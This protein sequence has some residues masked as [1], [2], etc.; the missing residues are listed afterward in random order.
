M[1]SSGKGSEERRWNGL[2][3]GKREKGS[4]LAVL[5]CVG[6]VLSCLVMFCLILSCWAGKRNGDRKPSNGSE[7]MVHS[8]GDNGKGPRH[9]TRGIW[10]GAMLKVGVRGR[11]RVKLRLRVRFFACPLANAREG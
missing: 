9:R 11:V 3:L 4:V 10:V 5:R 8:R 7:E 1:G 6:L 2:S